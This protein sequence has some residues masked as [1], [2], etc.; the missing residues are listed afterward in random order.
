MFGAV[1]TISV[2]FG[3]AIRMYHNDHLP[4]H[5]HAEYQGRTGTFS[6]NG[7]VIAGS[8]T[9]LAAHRL[10]REWAALHGGELE[11]NWERARQSQA[12]ASIEPLR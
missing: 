5:F 2:F 8:I 12:I 11:D 6:L 7:E 4:P 1:P 10:I 3:I 9:S